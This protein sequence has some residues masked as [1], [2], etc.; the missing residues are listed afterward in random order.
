MKTL[1][2]RRTQYLT[3]RAAAE[4]KVKDFPEISWLFEGLGLEPV[5]RNMTNGQQK[6]MAGPMLE[7]PTLKDGGR[8]ERASARLGRA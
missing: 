3:F 4:K 5:S 6:P 7:G 2:K 8:A 1:P